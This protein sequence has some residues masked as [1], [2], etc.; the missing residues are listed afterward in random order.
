MR[1]TWLCR[2]SA[3]AK[4]DA[5][6]ITIGQFEFDNI[7]YDAEVDVLYLHVGD[8]STAVDFDESPEG[9]ALR[10]DSTGNLVGVTILNAQHRLD[11]DGE[12]TITIPEVVHVTR[13]AV[14]PALANA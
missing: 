13:D 7:F 6:T 8:P 10:F 5:M 14:A 11:H 3:R 12:L 2:N 1:T 4:I 9:H